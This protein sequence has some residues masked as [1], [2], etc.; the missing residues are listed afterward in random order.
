MTERMAGGEVKPNYRLSGPLTKKERRE[1]VC[2]LFCALGSHHHGQLIFGTVFST[3]AD[4]N[5]LF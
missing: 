5:M 1:L 3:C 2:G 4:I